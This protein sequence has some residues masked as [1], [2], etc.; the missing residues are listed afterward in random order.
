MMAAFSTNQ[1][2]LSVVFIAIV[3]GVCIGILGEKA[4]NFKRII[5]EAN[6][7]VQL[8]IN[9]LINKVGPIAIFH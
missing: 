5:E 2:V 6:E 3:V 8:F 4:K 9:F 1:G 7:I